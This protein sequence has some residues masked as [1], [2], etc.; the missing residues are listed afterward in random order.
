[1]SAQH[2]NQQAGSSETYDFVV[3]GSG[4]G[5]LTGALTAAAAGLHT[6]VLEKGDVLGGMTAY[7]GGCMWLPGNRVTAAVKPEDSAESG[8]TYLSGIAGDSAPLEMQRAYVDTS[9]ELVDALQEHS[10]VRFV[11]QP[12][13]DYF[14]AEGRVPGGRGIFAV[15][16]AITDAGPLACTIRPPVPQDRLGLRMERTELVGGQALIARLLMALSRY[17]NA[18]IRTATAMTE[19]VVA[20]GRVVGVRADTDG[21]DTDYFARHGVLLNAGGFEANQQLR[22][23]WQGNREVRWTAAPATHTGDAITAAIA[24]GAATA[25]MHEA[26]WAPMLA[27]P[28]NSS[29]FLV[30]FQGGIFVNGT[31]RRFGNEFLPYGRMGQ[32]ILDLEAQGEPALPVWWIFDDRFDTVPCAVVDPI[33]IPEFQSAGLWH[34]DATLAGLAQKIGVPHQA[35][36]DT[37]VRFNAFAEAGVDADFHR[38]ADEYDQFFVEPAAHPNPC[39]VP[40]DRAPF[41][42]VQLGLGDIG[43][44][45]GVVTNPDGQVLNNDGAVIEGLYAAGNTTASATGHVY[46]GP[47]APIATSMVF[48]Y[49]SARHAVGSHAP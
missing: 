6:L 38:G 15:P 11:Y 27:R 8:F 14:D 25:R 47:G 18:T 33:D 46:V 36:V 9:R 13:P 3:V 39:L 10:D 35:L 17:P 32:L 37:V 19:L 40:I 22:S 28:E 45:G 49:R 31:G 43:T 41:H 1:M 16:V 44:K 21:I 24:V 20:D 23:R 2:H 29:T 42:A 30:G 34:T 4:A 7:A 48:A 5:G 12:F 26:W